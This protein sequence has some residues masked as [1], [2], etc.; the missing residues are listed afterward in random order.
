MEGYLE[1]GF[2]VWGEGFIA[3]GMKDL[4]CFVNLGFGA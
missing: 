4:R 1:F 2:R 3:S